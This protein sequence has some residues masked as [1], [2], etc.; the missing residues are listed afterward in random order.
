MSIV[1]YC[2]YLVRRIPIFFNQGAYKLVLN[3]YKV[4]EHIQAKQYPAVG[5]HVAW[6]DFTKVL[7]SLTP[8]LLFFGAK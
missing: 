7:P 4:N 2:I 5:T 6:P 8:G 3:H 1:A